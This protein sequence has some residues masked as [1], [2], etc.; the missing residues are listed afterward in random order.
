MACLPYASAQATEYWAYGDWQVY[1]EAFDTGED[2]QVTCT[3]YTGGDGD[4]TVKLTTSSGDAGP[5]E[6][7]PQVVVSE[8]AFRGYNTQM[9]NGQA[10]ALIIDQ[11]LEYYALVDGYFNSEGF[12]QADAHMRWQDAAYILLGMKSG[13]HLDVR[14][15]SPTQASE[16]VYLASLNGF[17]AAYGK[18]MDSCGHSVEVVEPALD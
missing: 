18:M 7:Y 1:V 12:V 8:Q 11:T 9:Q 14:L 3:A 13:S 10:V 17:T 16:R 6:I 5:P 15:V 2:V 4:P